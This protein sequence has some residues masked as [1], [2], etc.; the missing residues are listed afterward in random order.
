MSARKYFDLSGA[1]RALDAVGDRWALLIVRELL[2][3][4]KR[5][6]DLRSGLQGVS[7]NVLSQRLRD[8]EAQSVVRRVQLG[9]PLSTYAYEL[10]ELGLALEPVLVAL[11]RWG[12]KLPEIEG[13]TMSPGA[14]ALML[15]ELYTPQPGSTPARIRLLVDGDALDIDVD[16]E[17]ITVRRASFGSSESAHR[18]AVITATIDTL[19]G[20]MLSDTPIDRVIASGDLVISGDE[21]AARRFLESFELPHR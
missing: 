12:A 19:R 7:Q 16:A 6:G 3:G 15:N 18:T 13:A 9:P 8:L 20:V 5:F 2:L 11:S 4:P 1:G 17:T 10:T 21:A 14:Y